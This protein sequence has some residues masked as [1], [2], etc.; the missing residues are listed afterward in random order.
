VRKESGTPSRL[1]GLLKGHLPTQVLVRKRRSS[2]D[3]VEHR[4]ILGSRRSWSTW[5]AAA[6]DSMQRAIPQAELSEKKASRAG[7]QAEAAASEL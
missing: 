1:P 7:Q 6:A 4:Q 2:V 5:I 3:I